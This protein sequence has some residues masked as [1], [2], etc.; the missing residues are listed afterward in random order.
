MIS[1]VVKTFHVPHFSTELVTEREMK[2]RPF[3]LFLGPSREDLTWAVES[4]VRSLVKPYNKVALISHESSILLSTSLMASLQG[5][6]LEVMVENLVEKDI[7]PT[8]ARLRKKGVKTM[9]VDIA[10]HLVKAFVYQ[11]SS[12]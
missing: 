7:R 6:R 5:D 9:I 11:V 3:T 8:L 4:T 1:D 12:L 10:S 2:E